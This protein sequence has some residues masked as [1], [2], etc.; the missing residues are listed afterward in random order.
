MYNAAFFFASSFHHTLFVVDRPLEG[1]SDHSDLGPACLKQTV[2]SFWLMIYRMLHSLLQACWS[3][4]RVI[5]NAA[6]IPANVLGGIILAPEETI[7]LSRHPLPP[8]YNYLDICKTALAKRV[9]VNF[10]FTWPFLSTWEFL[11]EP[12]GIFGLRPKSSLKMR[13]RRGTFPKHYKF[14][15]VTLVQLRP[16]NASKRSFSSAD[17]SFTA[18]FPPGGPSHSSI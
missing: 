16:P 17:L 3:Q 6:H 18:V 2:L 11:R 9:C 1:E 14:V 13:R 12:F 4:V 15:G 8:L 10:E 7:L 5:S